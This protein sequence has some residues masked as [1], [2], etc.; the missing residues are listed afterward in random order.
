[1]EMVAASKIRRVQEKTVAG[2]PY[3]EKLRS[4]VGNL[5]GRIEGENHPYLVQREKGKTLLVLFSSDKGLAGSLNTNL[6]REFLKIG[7]EQ[8][9]T[10]IISIGK[11]LQKSV[12]RLG[13]VLVA[14]FPFGTTLPTFESIL[15]ISKLIVDEFLA[16]GYKNVICLYTQFLSL[17]TQKPTVLTLLPIQEETEAQETVAN[18]DKKHVEAISDQ[19]RPYTFEP[20]ASELLT[21][22]MPH[23]VELTLYQIFLES[24]ASEQAAR[25]IAM[26]QASEN[27]KDV[28]WELSLMYNKVRQ[29]RITSE[30]LD[31]TGGSLGVAS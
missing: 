2:K 20:N 18:G 22:L 29:E 11:K 16:N 27:A 25:M 9:D 26:H 15:P 30:I 3:A 6:L 8:D 13:G 31:V 14:D 4:L 10:E 17:G 23:Y 5:V 7:G 12:V 24:Y 21:A 28:I 19:G 1:M